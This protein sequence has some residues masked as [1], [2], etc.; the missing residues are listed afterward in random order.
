MAPEPNRG[1]RKDA[2]NIVYII[3]KIAQIKNISVAE[4]ERTAEEKAYKLFKK[5]KNSCER[6]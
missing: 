3:D 2:S 5:I 1:K 6:G 4:V